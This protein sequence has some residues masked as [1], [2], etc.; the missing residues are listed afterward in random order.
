ML[1]IS[2]GYLMPVLLCAYHTGMRLGEILGLTWDR[3]DLKA[4]FIRLKE[5]ATKTGDARSIPIGRE[6]GEVLRPARGGGRGDGNE[7]HWT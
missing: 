4:G 2:P 1:K 7:D 6:L 5:A 3:V